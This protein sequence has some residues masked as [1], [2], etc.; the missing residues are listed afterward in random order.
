M[1]TLALECPAGGIS[2]KFSI[3]QL[4]KYVKFRGTPLNTEFRK[5][6]ISPELF[7]VGIIDTLFGAEPVT[8]QLFN[9]TLRD[10]IFLRLLPK[11][12]ACSFSSTFSRKKMS[13]IYFISFRCLIV[14]CPQ[15]LVSYAVF[16]I[17]Y[18]AQYKN[19]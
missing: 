18:D 16:Q 12:F 4:R 7:F 5:I 2:P 14:Y 9:A 11:F 10:Y 3:P 13:A 17:L 1:D 8:V 15:C 6:R 19:F